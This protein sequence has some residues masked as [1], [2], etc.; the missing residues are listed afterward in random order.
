MHPD[1][2]ES[3]INPLLYD[4]LFHHLSNKLVLDVLNFKIQLISEIG[5]KIKPL[6]NIY[7]NETPVFNN[8]QIQYKPIVPQNIPIVILLLIKFR[9][10]FK[11]LL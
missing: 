3:V 1:I 4:F 5:F 10:F 11:L 2:L 6:I 7:S 9:M 8:C